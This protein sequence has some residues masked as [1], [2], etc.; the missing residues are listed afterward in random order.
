MDFSNKQ[1]VV[2]GGTGA[3][4][5]AVVAGLLRAG[6][7]C[8]IPYRNE[9]EAQRFAHRGDPNVTL[10]AAGDLADETQVAKLY[11]GLTP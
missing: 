5:A 8:V 10:I 4:G 6:A 11:S 2:T 3:L 1:V 7:R 9:A